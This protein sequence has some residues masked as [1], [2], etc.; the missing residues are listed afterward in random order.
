MYK[1][2]HPLFYDTMSERSGELSVNFIHPMKPTVIRLDTI[3]Q[4]RQRTLFDGTEGYADLIVSD[5]YHDNILVTKAEA[6]EITRDLLKSPGDGLASAVTSLTASVNR[7][8]ELLRARM[9]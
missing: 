4:V 7:L 1:E 5:D 6:D 3:R 2:I 8:Y 9:H